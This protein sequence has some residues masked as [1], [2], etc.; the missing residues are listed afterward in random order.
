MRTRAQVVKD[1][2]Y[3]EAMAKH[4]GNEYDNDGVFVLS[5]TQRRAI[6]ARAA[7]RYRAELADFDKILNRSQS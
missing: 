5:A 7:V 4:A 2:G 1:L 6:F 3:A